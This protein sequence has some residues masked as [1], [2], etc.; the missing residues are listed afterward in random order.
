MFRDCPIFATRIASPP[1]ATQAV[2][3]LIDLLDQTDHEFSEDCLSV[4]VWAKPQV[5]EKKKAVM[6][7]IYGGG[8]VS[9]PSEI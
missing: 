5:G 2:I 6:L 4:N 3:N 8:T 9:R 1:N 7:W